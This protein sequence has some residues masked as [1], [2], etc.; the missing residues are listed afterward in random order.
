MKSTTIKL[1]AIVFSFVFMCTNAF[2]NSGKLPAQIIITNSETIYNGQQQG[3]SVE[4]VPAGLNVFVTYNNY[5][6]EPVN[7]GKYAI[8]VDIIDDTYE[9]SVSSFFNIY[10]AIATLNILNTS[11]VYDG[12]EKTVSYETEPAGLNVD[13]TYN[14]KTESP[15]NAGN[16]TVMAIINEANYKGGDVVNFKIN[17]IQ[18]EIEILSP[19]NLVYDGQMHS[20]IISTTPD[21]LPFSVVYNNSL[22]TPLNAGEYVIRATITDP[23]YSAEVVKNLIIEK[24]EIE[25]SI[26]A[27]NDVYS[28]EEKSVSVTT[29]LPNIDVDVYYNGSLKNP[30]NAGTYEVAAIVNHPNYRGTATTNYIIERAPVTINISNLTQAYDGNPKP[31][32]VSTSPE[33]VLVDVFYNGQKDAPVYVGDFFVMAK[34]ADENFIGTEMAALVISMQEQDIVW[35]QNLSEIS[36]GDEIELPAESTVGLE[37]NY[38]SSNPEVADV[39]G[40]LLQ[41]QGIG[42]T[43]LTAFQLGT[44]NISELYDSVEIEI[45]SSG[46]EAELTNIQ[47]EVWPNPVQEYL[48]IN[49]PEATKVDVQIINCSGNLVKNQVY[50]H[51]SLNVDMTSYS[52]GLY[53]V[54]IKANG[55]EKELKILKQ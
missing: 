50:N 9:G 34:V 38:K 36:V 5:Y 44:E 21:S 49:S 6:E 11:T 7:A 30:V 3:I 48:F 46:L 53:I 16:Y 47:I 45:K 39:V 43:V 51:S 27:E 35:E 22:V 2:S 19:D 4:T 15:I 20:A 31:V 14:G 37:L 8:T 40:N 25:V 26:M 10:K 33:N 12:E 24:A 55:Q 28:G 41:V 23:N 18:A 52:P 42:K 17:P 13:I 1:L 54:K 29:E 32:I